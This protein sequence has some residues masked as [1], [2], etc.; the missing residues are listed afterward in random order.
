MQNLTLV[1]PAKFES[2]TL[3][4]VL[5]EIDNLKLNCKKMYQ[6]C[7]E[8]TSPYPRTLTTTHTCFLPCS[9]FC[10]LCAVAI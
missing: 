9:G 7:K 1:I 5:K 4:D 3:P 8:H 6:E 10:T 2:T